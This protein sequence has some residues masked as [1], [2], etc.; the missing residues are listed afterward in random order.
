M[1]TQYTFMAYAY[2]AG[3]ATGENLCHQLGPVSL[4]A[5]SFDGARAA[6]TLWAHRYADIRGIDPSYV[7]LSVVEVK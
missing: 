3:A 4:S 2:T 7:D 6:A 5:V 1:A